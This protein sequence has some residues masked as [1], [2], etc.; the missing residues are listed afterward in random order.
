MY[1]V[2]ISYRRKY[3]FAIAKMISEL[4]R[5]SGVN[6]FVDLDE[7]RSGTFDDKIIHA[8]E[9]A[10][11]F[12]LILT[13]GA[14]DRCGDKDDWLTKE[15]TAAVESG[16]NIIPVLCEGFEWPKQ[17]GS[18][19]SDTIKLLSNYNSVVMSYEYV[20][21]MIDKIIGYVKG[22]V[23]KCAVV[24]KK[25][26]KELPDNDIDSF[27]REFVE[28]IDEV[29]GVDFAFHAGSAWHQDMD[30]IEVLGAL[31][32]AGKK[33][34]VIVN[35]PEVAD[36]ISKYMRHKLKKY[37]AFDEAIALWKNLESMY[38]NVEVRVSDVPLLRIYYSFN[39]ADP[40]KNKTKVKFYTHGNSKISMNYAQIFGASSPA[41][42]LYKDEFELLWKLAKT[43]ENQ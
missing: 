7:L 20:D 22:D 2:F 12:V 18:E 27:F 34:R 6:A 13:P 25:T 16:R 42:K 3:G 8:I 4:L 33:I 31:A 30:R 10:P 41:Y 43:D 17:W 32:D 14:L 26:S 36:S 1:D 21:A 37:L 28:N 5:K 29:C 38:D 39:M 11:A 9:S 35:S 40:E 23:V 19:I 15:I 24:G